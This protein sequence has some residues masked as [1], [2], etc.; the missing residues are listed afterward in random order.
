[1]NILNLFPTQVGIVKNLGTLDEITQFIKKNEKETNI[2]EFL[3]DE[4]KFVNFKNKVMDSVAEYL[5]PQLKF[6]KIEML[7]NWITNNKFTSYTDLHNHPRA[8]VV[9]VYYVDS[10]PKCGDLILI[11]PRSSIRWPEIQE[12]N[13]SYNTTSNRNTLE[14]NGK[15]SFRISPE[16]DMLVIF[17]G[18]MAH[19][20]EPN[21]NPTFVRRSVGMNFRVISEDGKLY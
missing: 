20:V 17:P 19:S 11:D 3:N 9:A 12:Y 10:A 14:T 2:K 18:Y 15:R 1:M 5:T 4:T 6:S 16:K 8:F 21:L 7:E 13:V